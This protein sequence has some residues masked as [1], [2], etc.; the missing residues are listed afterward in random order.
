MGKKALA[1]KGALPE[2]LRTIARRSE[3]ELEDD[4]NDS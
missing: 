3:V 4:L 1:K 2:T